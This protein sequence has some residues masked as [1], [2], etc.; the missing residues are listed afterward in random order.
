MMTAPFES[1]RRVLLIFCDIQPLQHQPC[2]VEQPV[3]QGTGEKQGGEA[4]MS[5]S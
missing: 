3:E 5:A 4:P 2:R 1:G